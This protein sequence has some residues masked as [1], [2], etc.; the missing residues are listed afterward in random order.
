MRVRPGRGP[1]VFTNSS[2]RN[3]AQRLIRPDTDG[4][5]LNGRGDNT[6]SL[7]LG[8]GHI[9]D[10]FT[11]FESWKTNPQ[12]DL[13]DHGNYCLAEPGKVY[14]IYLPHGGRVSVR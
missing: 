6:Q 10:F 1:G 11:S 12:D 3:A 9:V 14:A 8:Y 13:V 7:F 2:H 4:G 5:R